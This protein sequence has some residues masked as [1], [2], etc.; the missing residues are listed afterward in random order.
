MQYTST[1]QSPMGNMLLACDEAG[2]TGIWFEGG[3]YYAL[4]LEEGHE[5]K[6][7]AFLTDAKRWLDLYFSGKKP[8]FTPPLHMTGSE[9]RMEVWRLLLEI[10]YG[11]VITY[12]EIAKKAAANRGLAGMS[13]QAAGGAVGH[14]PISIIVP[15]HRVVGAD[16][17]LTGYGGGIDRKASLLK[18][19]GVDMS[20]LYVPSKG[21]AL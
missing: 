14:N 8:D 2:L 20:S 7:R 4:G 11:M 19:E 5:R 15:C 21:T 9:F 6:E 18:L 1:Y 10:P 17:S 13:A 16:G 12:G 3:R